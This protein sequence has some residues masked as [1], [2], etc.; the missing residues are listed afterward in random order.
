MVL[1]YTLKKNISMNIQGVKVGLSE[2]MIMLMGLIIV[3][4]I[5]RAFIVKPKG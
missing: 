4:L 3:F 2:I 1:F 5:I